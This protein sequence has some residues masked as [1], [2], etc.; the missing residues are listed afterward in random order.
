MRARMALFSS[1]IRVEL[2]EVILKEM[3]DQLLACS[4]KGTVPVLVLPDGTVIDESRD[5]MA[6]ALSRF[7]PRGWLPADD[8][9]QAETDALIYENDEVFKVDLDHYKYAV[10]Y[11]EH[12]PEHYRAQGERFLRRLEDR[13]AASACLVGERPGLA[14][15]AVFPFVRQF[16]FVDRAWFDAAPYPRLQ[17][18][19]AGLL[20]ADFFAAVMQKYP[21]WHAGDAPVVF[22]SGASGIG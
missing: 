15:I 8:A 20:A 19:L 22:P 6:W 5:I 21:Q 9:Q 10:R 16:A 14:D 13:L 7:D 18:W 3:P 4:P 11:P 12:P 17:Q 2:R 1:G